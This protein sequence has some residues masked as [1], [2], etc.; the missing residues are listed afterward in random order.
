MQAAAR[1]LRCI[2]VLRLPPPARGKVKLVFANGEYLLNLLFAAGVDEL[3][4]ILR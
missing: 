2:F 4:E 3:F 1:A